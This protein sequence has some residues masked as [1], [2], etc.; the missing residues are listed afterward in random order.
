[1]IYNTEW[2]SREGI[3]ETEKRNMKLLFT[4]LM[5]VNL[6]FGE[7]LDEKTAHRMSPEETVQLS[8]RIRQELSGKSGSRTALL[9]AEQAPAVIEVQGTANGPYTVTYKS[10]ES[11]KANTLL[12]F[13]IILPDGNEITL[14]AFVT[15]SNPDGSGWKIYAEMWNGQL[16]AMW[17]SG[18]TTFRVIVIPPSGKL[19]MTSGTVVNRACCYNNGFEGP[20][21]RADVSPDGSAVLLEGVFSGNTYALLNG[22]PIDVA[23][24]SKGNAGEIYKQGK[25]PTGDVSG[26]IPLTICSNGSCSSR[27]IYITRPQ[28][29]GKG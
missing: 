20:L 15:S 27:V 14:D 7:F 18:V 12:A 19:Q 16:A 26:Q 21:Q 24:P 13:Q 25:I 23:F 8:A 3:R 22:Q 29:S 5:L 6:A 1:M 17:P 2:K 11:H 4:C 28:N 9:Q 10:V